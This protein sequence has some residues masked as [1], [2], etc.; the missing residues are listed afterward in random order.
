MK[1]LPVDKKFFL[2]V[3][4]E[5]RSLSAYFEINDE[6]SPLVNKLNTVEK[7]IKH[8][9]FAHILRV[10]NGP[11]LVSEYEQYVSSCKDQGESDSERSEHSGKPT[12]DL[13]ESR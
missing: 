8:F 3:I 2:N 12:N 9:S 7:V 11:N 4:E 5:L 1:E 13:E 6:F 10:L